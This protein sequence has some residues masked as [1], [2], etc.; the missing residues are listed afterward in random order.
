MSD[1]KPLA[2]PPRPPPA[3]PLI[4]GKNNLRTAPI[5]PF[6]GAGAAPEGLSQ[7]YEALVKKAEEALHWYEVS[8]RAK[9]RGAHIT[10]SVAIGLGA[11]AA[12]LPT[13]VTALPDQLG[14]YPVAR[15]NPVAT[16]LGVV[17]GTMVLLDKLYGYSSSWI[18]YATAY[19]AI[20]GSLEAFKLGWQ[21]KL[22][23]LH[24]AQPSTEQVRGLFDFLGAFLASVN[25][26][27]Q[28]ET[29][30]WVAEFKG[31]LSE[32]DRTME[33][34]RLTAATAPMPVTRGALRVEIVPLELLDDKRWTL[35]LENGKEEVKEGQFS[36]VVTALEPGIYKL[37][38]AAQKKGRPVAVE[39]PIAIKAGE[40][41]EVRLEKIG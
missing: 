26:A 15:L 27:V 6:Q 32:L 38:V 20:Q 19:Q 21:R 5:S 7:V 22:Y 24:P 8:Q 3:S 33:A 11:L 16:A 36:A 17:A 10:R 9:R 40:V 30:S 18:R 14:D 29:Q 25:A 1:T 31:A 37:R 28:G 39:Q 23:E 13:V 41:F 4:V 12:I 34:E 2:I 35:Q